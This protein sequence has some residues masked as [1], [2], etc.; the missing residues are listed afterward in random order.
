MTWVSH[1]STNNSRP[2][3]DTTTMAL[4]AAP[5]RAIAALPTAWPD[6]HQAPLTRLPPM[7]ADTFACGELYQNLHHL[8][9][10]RRL[11]QCPGFL[12][13]HALDSI[14]PQADQSRDPL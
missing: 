5:G 1:C 4:P 2:S 7:W 9:V 13:A 6:H 11:P 3:D 12:R 10:G 8:A 14:H